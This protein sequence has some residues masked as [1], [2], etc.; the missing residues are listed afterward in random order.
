M[1]NA[2]E[3]LSACKATHTG[4]LP[5]QCIVLIVSV[6]LECAARLQHQDTNSSS[7]TIRHRSAQELGVA[8]DNAPANIL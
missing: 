8:V 4:D 7:G 1:M 3:G 5:L 6:S 2:S